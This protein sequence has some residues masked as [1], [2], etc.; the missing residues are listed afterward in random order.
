V[1]TG[2]QRLGIRL[3]VTEAVLGHVSGGRGGIVGVYQRHDWAAEQRDALEAWG[4]AHTLVNVL[5]RAV[6]SALWKHLLNLFTT[7]ISRQG[8]KI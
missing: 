8:H 4:G 5:E 2:L 3:E 7:L 1:A 6:H